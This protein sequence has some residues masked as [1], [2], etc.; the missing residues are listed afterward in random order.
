MPQACHRDLSAG[1]ATATPPARP[2]WHVSRRSHGMTTMTATEPIAPPSAP[3]LTQEPPAAEPDDVPDPEVP[4][5]VV[6]MATPAAS[7]QWREHEALLQGFC[8]HIFKWMLDYHK[9]MMACVEATL[10]PVR[11]CLEHA[12]AGNEHAQY[13][14]SDALLK[15]QE[16][17]IKVQTTP[18]VATVHAM[19][20]QG[21]VLDLQI[22]KTA[23]PELVEALTALLSWLSEAGFTGVQVH[24]A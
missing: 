24:T 13:Q 18:Y 11:Q 16:G 22:Q 23:A 19:T 10:G 5:D 12:A 3:L 7:A 17:G 20:P 2:G 6:D 4:P 9:Q 15:M 14:L 1:T 8:Q 21:Y